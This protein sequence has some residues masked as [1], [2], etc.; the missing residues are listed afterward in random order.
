M[1]IAAVPKYLV[2]HD[3]STASP[4]LRFG[5][6]LPLWGVNSRTKK[7]LWTTHDINYRVAGQNL[8]EREFKDE[9][10]TAA[11]GQAKRLTVADRSMMAALCRRQSALAQRLVASGQLLTINAS[12]V[13]PFT[14]GLGNAH[15]MENGF[16]FLN[17][18]GLP[19]LSGS[20]V[21]GVLRQSAR[22]LE[23]G[24]WGDNREWT[25]AAITALF[26]IE[27]EGGGTEHQRGALVFWDVIPLIF[28]DE[29]MVDVMT[30]HQNHYYQNGE[31][32]HESGSPN[33]I[34]FLTVPPKSLF[35]FFVQCDR[36]FLQKL[37]PELVEND[38][39]RT[40]LHAAFE[41]AFDWL[42]F[43]A[44][45]A[46]GYGAMT[47][48][49][50]EEIARSARE[51]QAA[52]SKCDWVDEKIAELA[53]K[54]NANED[55]TLRGRGLAEAWAAITDT[56]LKARALSDIRTRWE[57]KEWWAAPPG[58]AAKKAKAI[59]DGPA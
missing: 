25:T 3:F 58:G 29:L 50:D 38:R 20:G 9:N 51:A 36:S 23:K 11:L 16:A 40:L 59:Y 5:M 17:P 47:R 27:A 57:S 45:T 1:A 19:Y 49:S 52:A 42:G 43:G 26:G 28:G 7:H 8:E 30:A 34:N 21:K 15:P 32:P 41:H 4:G 55:D 48:R 2:G 18:Y 53:K 14:T 33:P 31:S 13:A 46:V 56:E 12:A 22:E 24:I 10:K 39:W 6:Y 44:K 37:A 54:N 35:T